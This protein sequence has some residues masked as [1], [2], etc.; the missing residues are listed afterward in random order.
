MTKKQEI[1]AVISHWQRM[2][3]WVEKQPKGERPSYLKM[4]VEIK[5]YWQGDDC[6]FCNLYC[7]PYCPIVLKHRK[8]CLVN[9][10]GER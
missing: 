1:K 9:D 8:S 4:Q 3:K 5:E 2:I 7:C 6:I 10:K